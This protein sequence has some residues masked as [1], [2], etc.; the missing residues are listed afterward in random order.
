MLG[1]LLAAT[2]PDLSSDPLFTAGSKRTTGHDSK[3]LVSGARA[4]SNFLSNPFF[5][6]FTALRDLRTRRLTEKDIIE[7]DSSEED[8]GIKGEQGSEELL[9]RFMEV[10]LAYHNTRHRFSEDR[11]W[12]TPHHLSL[13]V[14]VKAEKKGFINCSAVDDGYLYLSG[15]SKVTGGN[16]FSK[17]P[18]VRYEAKTLNVI[19]TEKK[20]KQIKNDYEATAQQFAQMLSCIQLDTESAPHIVSN[21]FE[22]FSIRI[23]HT[24][25]SIARVYTPKA[26]LEDIL[27][28]TRPKEKPF[29]YFQTT[30]KFDLLTS[31]GREHAAKAIWA[32]LLH[33]KSGNALVG[34][35]AWNRRQPGGSVPVWGLKNPK[36]TCFINAIFQCLAGTTELF[37][38]RGRQKSVIDYMLE[39]RSRAIEKTYL[40]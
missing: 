10:I 27:H 16:R 19:V 23:A 24:Y 37:D 6:F 35:L 40:G 11:L 36:D 21:G 4:I 17:I 18:V 26:Y 22:A 8:E 25:L 28:N 1:N 3:P 14:A 9:H 38:S 33:L 32:L 20:I 2:E 34:R 7:D 13:D 39:S 5:T 12:S 31:G 29:I 30:E 15:S